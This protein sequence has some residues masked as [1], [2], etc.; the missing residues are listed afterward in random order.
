MQVCTHLLWA[1]CDADAAII[2]VVGAQYPSPQS[3]HTIRHVP[4]PELG[5]REQRL[6]LQEQKK[7][8]QK[9]QGEIQQ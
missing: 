1:E 3:A 4:I 2:I 5:P 6:Q 7:C 8:L 9:K